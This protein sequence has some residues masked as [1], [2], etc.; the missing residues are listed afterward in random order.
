MTLRAGK[1]ALLDEIMRQLSDHVGLLI[2]QAVTAGV[3]T[4]RERGP[5]DEEHDRQVAIAALR[6]YARTLTTDTRAG[7]DAHQN[8]LDYALLIEN[9]LVA[10]PTP[11]DSPLLHPRRP[12]AH[13]KDTP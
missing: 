9:E 5:V 8:V 7:R 12:Y 10:V 4:A 6:S 1:S 3:I 2:E 13:R 11:A